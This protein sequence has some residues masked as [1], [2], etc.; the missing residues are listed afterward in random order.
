MFYGLGP[1]LKPSRPSMGAY[2]KGVIAELS[3]IL[4]L[5]P[6]GWRVLR[7]RDKGRGQWH[8]ALKVVDITPTPCRGWGE[9][10]TVSGSCR[11]LRE[12]QGRWGWGGCFL[13]FLQPRGACDPEAP[14]LPHY[15]SPMDLLP[16]G[17][18]ASSKGKTYLG[19]PF[20]RP[21]HASCLT[22]RLRRLFQFQLN[23]KFFR[24]TRLCCLQAPVLSSGTYY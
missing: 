5:L 11:G 22:S 2:C 18:W 23:V 9:G 21:S 16:V 14:V 10:K 7:Q 20:P 6:L 15:C 13:P 8:P 4:Y 19:I 3:E 24:S 17:A 12:E 1:F